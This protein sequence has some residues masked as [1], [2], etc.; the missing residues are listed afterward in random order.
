MKTLINR[1]LRKVERGEQ[2]SDKISGSDKRKGRKERQRAT[3][4]GS[5]FRLDLKTLRVEIVGTL[6]THVLDKPISLAN[7]RASRSKEQGAR[8]RR[9][10]KRCQKMER[11]A[12]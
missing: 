11:N 8:S 2:K 10:I 1:A 3:W 12:S 6:R 4:R 9:A 7:G 5:S